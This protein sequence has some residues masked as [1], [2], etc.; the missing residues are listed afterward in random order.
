QVT[1]QR[2]AEGLCAVVR[3][4]AVRRGERRGARAAGRR[5]GASGAEPAGHLDAA[6]RGQAGDQPAVADVYVQLA[7]GAGLERMNELRGQLAGG[8][9]VQRSTGVE[10]AGQ[11]LQL[12]QVLLGPGQVVADE[13]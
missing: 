7:L 10:L 6:L 11:L 1:G 12:A 9:E 2:R 4:G 3:E 8:R 13:D 5:P